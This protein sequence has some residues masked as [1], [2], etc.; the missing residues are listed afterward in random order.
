[1]R[2]LK[3]D[4]WLLT[5]VL[6]LV[7]MGLVIIY[8]SST[9]FAEGRGLPESFYVVHHLKKVLI[10]FTVM[11]VGLSVPYKHWERLARPVMILSLLLLLFL[12]ASGMVGRVNGARRWIS[13]ASFGLQPS[14]LAKVGIIFFL[15]RLLTVKVQEMHRFANGFL[16]SLAMALLTF[17]LILKQPNYSTAATVLCIAIAMVFAGG[18]RISHLFISAS[19]GIPALLGLMVASPYRLKRVMAFL[20]PDTNLASSYQSLQS[21]ISLGNGG[22]LGTGLGTST[23]KLGYLPMPFTDTIF[24]VMGEELGY[25]GTS[26]CLLLFALL[27]WRGLRTAF[28][29]PDRFGSLVALGATVSVAVNV[30]MHVG[31]CAKFFPTTGQPLPFVS[32]GGTSLC[33]A[34]FLMGVLLNISQHAAQGEPPAWMKDPAK[35]RLLNGA[36]PKPRKYP[37]IPAMAS[38]RSR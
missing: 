29:C 30:I 28:W 18:C 23:Q 17:A 32:Y 21:L 1:V 24:A 20:H 12:I 16:A 7:G 35:V 34:L 15:A 31:V 5:A 6:A 38:R 36:G 22:F 25:I 3:I 10:G 33:T 19:A 11:L 37:A 8:S 26:L 2:S 27:I 13:F 14:E 4:I 9:A